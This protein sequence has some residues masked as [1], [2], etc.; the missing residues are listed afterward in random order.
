MGVVPS[1]GRIRP[2]LTGQ[3]YAIAVAKPLSLF[4]ETYGTHQ[5]D[6]DADDVANVLK[7]EFDCRP[8]AMGKNMKLR[9]PKYLKTAA[10]SH[11][12]REPFVE[13]DHSYFEWETV[14]DLRKYLNMSREE[15]CVAMQESDHLSRW[16]A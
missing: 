10:Y 16:V 2:K 12:G 9:E 3:E 6:L 13:D 4:V 14:K 8:G 7:T 11:F 5:G 15:I 1:P